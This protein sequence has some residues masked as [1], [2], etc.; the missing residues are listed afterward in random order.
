[1]TIKLC[2]F[3]HGGHIHVRVFTNGSISG[4]MV[5]EPDEWAVYRNIFVVGNQSFLL[6]QQELFIEEVE[7]PPTRRTA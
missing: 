3:S 4:G 5:L 7:A 1:M 2:Y 6:E